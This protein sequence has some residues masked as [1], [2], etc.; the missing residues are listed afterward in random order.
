MW[1]EDVLHSGLM[2]D[3]G[4]RKV[5]ITT[6][7]V[8]VDK[9][10]RSCKPTI[11]FPESRSVIDSCE[12]LPA[13]PSYG[14]TNRFKLG[15]FVIFGLSVAVSSETPRYSRCDNGNLD[16]EFRQLGA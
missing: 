1:L 8:K 11:G 14:K 12:S 9:V 7:S 6:E 2:H 3:P 15:L 16:S 13:P 10:D 5:L 4:G